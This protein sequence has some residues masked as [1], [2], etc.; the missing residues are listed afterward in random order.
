MVAV[1]V[2]VSLCA[3]STQIAAPRNC[4][5]PTSAFGASLQSGSY[6]FVVQANGK[7]G[8]LGLT[9]QIRSATVTCVPKTCAARAPR[10]GELENCAKA[11]RNCYCD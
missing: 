10:P 9:A 5:S 3:A 11:L 8:V 4:K 6:C 2:L 7:P 1:L